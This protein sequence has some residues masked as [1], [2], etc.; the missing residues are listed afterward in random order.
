ML[1]SDLLRPTI[2]TID[3]LLT[4]FPSVVLASDLLRPMITTIDLL[5]T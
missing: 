5:L 4:E 3:L 1:A 2:A